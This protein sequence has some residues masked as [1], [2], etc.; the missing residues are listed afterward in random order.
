MKQSFIE[1]SVPQIWKKAR[2]R[3]LFKSGD[4]SLPSNYRPISVLPEM[5]KITERVVFN[6]LM[7]FLNQN[8]L[9]SDFQYGFR[10]KHSCSDA[11]LS[12]LR[13][14]H[15]QLRSNKKVCLITLD[16]QKA[17]DSV[18]HKLLL[19]KLQNIGC[20]NQSMNWFNSY[21]TNR[22]QFVKNGNNE[23]DVLVVKKGVPQGS[24]LGSLLFCIFINDLISTDIDGH[25][26][27]YADDSSLICSADSYQELENKVNFSLSIINNW[28]KDNRLCINYRKSNFLVIN[29]SGRGIPGLNI[30]IDGNI[31]ENVLKTKILGVYFDSRLAFDKHIEYV[32]KSIDRRIGLFFRLRYSLPKNAINMLFKA[33]VQPIIDYGICV[34]GFTYKTH[35]EKIEKL[36]KR[37]AKVI[38]NSDLEI[39]EIYQ[40]L[41]WNSF[42]ERKYY[43]SAIFIYRC[44][45]GLSPI[46]CR[47]FFSIKENKIQTRSAKDKHLMLP[48]SGSVAFRNTI[49]YTG[50]QLYN[51]L[52]LELRNKSDF[53]SFKKCLKDSLS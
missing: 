39:K 15:S 30:S 26:Y 10:P 37:A 3:P 44:L 16:I 14:I 6:Q 25:I 21:L 7:D 45:N 41:K 40:K 17:F 29:L 46:I 28:M 43:F 34:Y 52:D 11:M 48:T 12:I 51:K 18:D 13:T 33:L 42:Q 4:R 9:L 36:I 53:N 23:S 32:S 38:D 49:F 2:V 1:S 35:Y 50:I 24:V 8:K 22:T 27:L 19:N 47:D 31:I 20:D 5:C